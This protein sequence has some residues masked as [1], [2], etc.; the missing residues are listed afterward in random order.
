MT[1]K[2]RKWQCVP[3]S[4]DRVN[5]AGNL[6]PIPLLDPTLTK[7]SGKVLVTGGLLVGLMDVIHCTCEII[8]GKCVVKDEKELA[9]PFPDIA[10]SFY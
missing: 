5:K 7:E 3:L 9:M 1:N 4:R 6:I 10:K 8:N 2:K